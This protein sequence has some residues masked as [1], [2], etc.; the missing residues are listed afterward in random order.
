M[1]QEIWPS[2]P[3]NWDV[4]YN[5]G[6]AYYLTGK[7]HRSRPLPEPRCEI[8]A[9]RPDGFFYLGLTKLKLGDINAAAANVQRAVIIRPDAD[10]YHFALGIIFKLQGNLSAALS[11][12]HQELDLD[13]MTPP[14]GSKPLKSKRH[15]RWDRKHR[16]RAP[17][18]H[19]RVQALIDSLGMCSSHRHLNDSAQSE[20][21]MICLP[22]STKRGTLS[23][24]NPWPATAILK[25]ISNLLKLKR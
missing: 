14:P 15:K 21:D 12:F 1:Y 5:L 10:H 19:R 7:L 16:H 6:Y 22:R 25:A 23:S 20:V 4:N 13:P 11:E 8:D 9:S 17:A 3:D 2:Q 24:R 18:H